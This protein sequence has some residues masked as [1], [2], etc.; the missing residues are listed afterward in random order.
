MATS[1]PLSAYDYRELNREV[2]SRGEVLYEDVLERKQAL[3]LTK[4]ERS[5]EDMSL[6][7]LRRTQF[8]EPLSESRIAYL[9]T[10]QGVAS[11]DALTAEHDSA[12][13]GT[14][15]ETIDP[16][17]AKQIA[18]EQ[19]A[20]Y[21][22]P[23]ITAR[24]GP[25]GRVQMDRFVDRATFDHIR[26]SLDEYG[27]G[28]GPQRK[29]RLTREAF[30]EAR[31]RANANCYDEVRR[32]LAPADEIW[33]GAYEVTHEGEIVATVTTTRRTS[34]WHHRAKDQVELELGFDLM[35]DDEL[36]SVLG[37][38]TQ[39][40][41][42]LPTEDSGDPND[43]EGDGP[44]Y[45]RVLICGSRNFEDEEFFLRAMESWM[46]KHGTPTTVV[47]GC[48]RGADSLA[49]WW[50]DRASTTTHPITIEH[51]PAQWNKHGKAAGPIRNQ[52]MLDEGK[53]EAVIAFS[54]DLSTS[55]GTRDM[56]MRSRRA[57]LPVWLP[58][59]NSDDPKAR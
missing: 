43:P 30:I 29:A 28:N 49:E 8:D 6:E 20:Y 38:D 17:T 50:A 12:R 44:M 18:W 54:P 57:G 9:T 13:Y 48:A 26:R 51:Y 16:I 58:I 37:S 39:P 46:E 36:E 33:H 7:E 21:T 59:P 45:E 23:V 42:L 34:T 22:G 5:I 55:R 31:K 47:E 1:P 27:I 11:L 35:A 3:A 53:P 25:D 14:P 40:L 10:G 2:W 56:V 4:H 24:R 41:P 19:R 32:Q 52:Q 15:Y